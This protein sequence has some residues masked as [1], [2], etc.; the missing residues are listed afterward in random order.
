MP[1]EGTEQD[2]PAQPWA[3]Q[4]GVW[5]LGGWADWVHFVQEAGGLQAGK[6]AQASDAIPGSDQD[7]QGTLQ[8]EN[9]GWSLHRE[10]LRASPGVPGT[11]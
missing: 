6:G 10:V 2:G 7:E 9:A 11:C 1:P 5:G 4:M 8:T 3:M